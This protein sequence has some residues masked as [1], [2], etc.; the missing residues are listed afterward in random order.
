MD[1][2]WSKDE[3]G[4]DLLDLTHLGKYRVIEEDGKFIAQ[5]HYFGRWDKLHPLKALE[6]PSLSPKEAALSICN[7]L[8]TH[9]LQGQALQRR[10]N[11]YPEERGPETPWGPTQVKVFYTDGMTFHH[12][13]GH[14]GIKLSDDLNR[15]IPSALR[16]KDGWYEEDCDW[17]IVAVSYPRH[18]TDYEHACAVDTMIRYYPEKWDVLKDR[19]PIEPKMAAA[20]PEQFAMKM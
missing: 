13:A 17:A 18:F 10:E 9:K 12:T 8:A 11:Y 20:E 16:T 7:Y 5:G 15:K 4:N 1:I 2:N 6:D 3:E 19:F 14:G